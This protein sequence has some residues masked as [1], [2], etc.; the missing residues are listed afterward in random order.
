MQ[1]RLTIDDLYRSEFAKIA[2][3]ACAD[4]ALGNATGHQ[5]FALAERVEVLMGEIKKRCHVYITPFTQ[6]RTL[7]ELQD[8]PHKVT[9]SAKRE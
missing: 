6:A 8:E 7:T 3:D 1:G 9:A 5:A 2:M 4:I